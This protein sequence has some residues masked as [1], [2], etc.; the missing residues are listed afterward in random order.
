MGLS[1]I[2]SE[3]N[4]DFGRKSQISNPHVFKPVVWLGGRVVRMLD[5]R[6]VDREF[7]SWSLRY[8]VQP[9]ASC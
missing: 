8:R 3:T 9:W 2:V 1:R 4:G 5:L 7:E 6:S